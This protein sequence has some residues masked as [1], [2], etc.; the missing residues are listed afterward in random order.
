[1]ARVLEG[2]VK[3]DSFEILSPQEIA[4]GWVLTCQA[5]PV[6]DHVRVVYEP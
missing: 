2:K 5:V 6:S 4:E 3:P 1:M